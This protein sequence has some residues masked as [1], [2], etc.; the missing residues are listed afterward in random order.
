MCQFCTRHGAGKKWYLN[1]RNLSVKLAKELG[2]EPWELDH[3]KTLDKVY[4]DASKMLQGVLSDPKMLE[5]TK[6]MVEGMIQKDKGPRK[7]PEGHLGQ[8]I[9]LEEAK[10]ICEVCGDIYRSMCPCRYMNRNEKVY[11]CMP[12]GLH[13]EALEGWVDWAPNGVEKL[14][15]DEG[16]A[17]LDEFDEKGLVHT[18]A[19]TPLPMAFSM[20]NCQYPECIAL[21]P[22]IDFD[23]RIFLKGHYVANVN[24]DNCIGCG[25]CATHCQFGAINIQ[26]TLG[27]AH[28][29]QFKCFGCG[30]CRAKCEQNAITLVPRDEIPAL[31]EEW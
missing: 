14:S 20:C 17:L 2:Y 24:I 23:I 29:N 1:E 16:K 7:F 25:S 9:T 8:V 11:T 19:G 28:I 12:L 4:G 22:R 30:L 10:K 6:K 21:R 18:I 5:P 3:W 31:R 26:P 13:G 15:I 27:R